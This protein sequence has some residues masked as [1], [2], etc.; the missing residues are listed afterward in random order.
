MVLFNHESIK[1]DKQWKR[2]ANCLIIGDGE[3]QT[4]VATPSS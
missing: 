3:S 1:I 4:A 2:I